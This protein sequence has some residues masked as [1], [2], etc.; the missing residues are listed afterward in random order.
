MVEKEY[1]RDE[2]NG[3]AAACGQSTSIDIE[4]KK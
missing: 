4:N 3:P 1:N 2:I